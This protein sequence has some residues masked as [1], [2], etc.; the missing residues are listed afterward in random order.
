[1]TKLQELNNKETITKIDE[2]P[3]TT[4][5]DHH[6]DQ[7]DSYTS[8]SNFEVQ[9][10]DLEKLSIHIEIIFKSILKLVNCEINS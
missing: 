5:R 6:V 2:N 8:I 1:M 3:S 10:H 7:N 4:S 9:D